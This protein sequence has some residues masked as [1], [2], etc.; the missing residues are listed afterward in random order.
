M[1]LVQKFINRLQAKKAKGRLDQM[2]KDSFEIK[3]GLEQVKEELEPVKEK[4]ELVQKEQNREDE[5]SRLKCKLDD[6]MKDPRTQK[7]LERLKQEEA[8]RDNARK[9]HAEQLR[10]ELAAETNPVRKKEL[11][12]QLF[13]ESTSAGQTGPLPP[14]LEDTVDAFIRI[15][16]NEN[17]Q[18]GYCHLF[19]HKKKTLLKE[20]GIDWK[21]PQEQNPRCHYD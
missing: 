3:E 7:E 4:L 9:I 20:Y 17:I 14:E 10:Q 2:K 16:L 15:Q 18:M 21:T 11:G 12:A 19:W 6:I 1:N 5:I 8:K 13:Q